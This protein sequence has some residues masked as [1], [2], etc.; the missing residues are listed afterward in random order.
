MDAV[1]AISPPQPI[2]TFDDNDRVTGEM[3]DGR[4]AG[5]QP[6]GRREEQAKMLVFRVSTEFSGGGFEDVGGRRASL[7]Y[8]PSACYRVAVQR[9]LRLSPARLN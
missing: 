9:Q 5:A 2:I 6:D 1:A 7:R 4:M 8:S 3:D